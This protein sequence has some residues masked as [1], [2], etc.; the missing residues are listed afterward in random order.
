MSLL[1]INGQNWVEI[2]S[3]A[4]LDIFDQLIKSSNV[5]LRS[6]QGHQG[7][8]NLST[9]EAEVDPS[10]TYRQRKEEI[11]RKGAEFRAAAARKLRTLRLNSAGLRAAKF[12]EII[13]LDTDGL[14]ELFS[15]FGNRSELARFLILEG[16][17]DDTY[18]QY[19]SLFH[20]GRLS[21]ND[22]KYLIKIRGFTD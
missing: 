13:R 7:H 15:A 16:H 4:T 14:D 10:R 3:I 5:S 19:T 9:L 2:S 11:E 22:N 21:P 6:Q 12:N 20:A 1:A 17:L 8:V 18:Y